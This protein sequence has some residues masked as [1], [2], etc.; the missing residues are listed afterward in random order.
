MNKAIVYPLW[1]APPLRFAVQELKALG[2]EVAE[3]GRNKVTHVLL[4]VPSPRV[5]GEELP[6]DVILIGG[7]LKD[8][9]D[10]YRKID[11][12]Q[13]AQYVAQNAAL[14]ADC[15]LRLLGQQ[16]G[17]AFQDCPILVIGWG[18]IGKCLCA[19]LKALG[20]KVTVAARKETD[21]GML[22][23]L[24][25]RA[26]SVEKINPQVYRAI[27]NTVP[28]PVLDC[29]DFAGVAIDL[30]SNQGLTGEK[31][32]WARGLPG[33]MLPESSGQLIARSVL[34]I[35]RKKEADQ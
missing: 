32:L 21:R 18:R 20:A 12:L 16:L 31:V 13:D 34:R 2:V 17:V 6:P 24:G 1:D 33:K 4:P 30:A 19:T 10:T 7:N 29:G 5:K 27:L 15:A 8:F 28:A 35:L 25:Y 23:A 26:V 11:L 22:K 3:S 14:T 9:P